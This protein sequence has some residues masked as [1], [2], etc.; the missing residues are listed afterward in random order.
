MMEQ[1]VCSEGKGGGAG[2]SRPGVGP[3][4]MG[5]GG[6]RLALSC[7]LAS[8]SCKLLSLLV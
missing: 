4:R 6:G 5:S 7:V 3:V 8:F 1:V 2:R